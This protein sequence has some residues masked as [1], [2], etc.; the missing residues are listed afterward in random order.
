LVVSSLPRTR[1]RATPEFIEVVYDERRWALLREL[2]AKAKNLMEAFSRRGIETWVHGSIARGD[3]WEKSD[4]DVVIP[5]RIPGYMVELILEDSGFKPYS[6]SIVA[7]TPTST[8]KGIIYLDDEERY[9]VSFPL[10]EFKPRELEFFKY[11]GLLTYQDLLMSKRV[12]GVNKNLVLIVPTPSGHLEAPV[13]GYED[14]VAKFLGV[15][16]EVVRERVEVLTRRDQV[17]RTGIFAKLAL[18]PSES[19]EEALERLLRER[20]LLRRT[21]EV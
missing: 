7:A 20:P 11:S 13:V 10:V 5:S 14:Y 17:G 18:A 6:R 1:V 8:P 15:S 12:P 21:I 3:V 2:R 4:V 16:V 19:F 9:S